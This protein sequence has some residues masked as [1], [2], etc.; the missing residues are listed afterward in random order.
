LLLGADASY[1]AAD[2][3]SGAGGAVRLRTMWLRVAAE[4]SR[5]ATASDM[6]QLS[7]A[8]LGQGSTEAEAEVNQR[9]S[10]RAISR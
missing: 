4:I 10:G 3:E 6:P 5:Q 9:R 8:F 7:I 2:E 1:S